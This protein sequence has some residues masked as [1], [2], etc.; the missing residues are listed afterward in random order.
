MLP[1]ILT[2]REKPF[3]GRRF[4]LRSSYAQIW[5]KSAACLQVLRLLGIFSTPFFSGIPVRQ[6]VRDGGRVVCQVVRCGRPRVPSWSVISPRLTANRD[7]DES[8]DRH[9]CGCGWSVLAADQEAF[10]MRRLLPLQIK[11]SLGKEE[12]ESTEWKRCKTDSIHHT[13]PRLPSRF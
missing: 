7:G 9:L 1:P 5:L 6:V 11:R 13:N 3:A 4:R 8:G 12:V 10:R 2:T